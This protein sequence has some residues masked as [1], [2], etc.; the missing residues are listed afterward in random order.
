VLFAHYGARRRGLAGAL[1][2]LIIGVLGVSVLAPVAAHADT[3]SL[4]T[5]TKSVDKAVVLPGQTFT[6][7]ITVDCSPEDCPDARLVDTIPAEFAALTVSPTVNV[8]GGPSTATWGGPDSRTL[9]VNFLKPLTD[10]GVGI[11]SGSGYS[12]QVALSVPANLSPDWAYNGVPV[13]NTAFA[14]SVNAPD[15]SASRDVTVNVPVTVNTTAAAD[16]TPATTR[17]KVGEASSLLLTTGNTS[18]AKATSLTIATPTDPTATTPAT[19]LFEAVNFDAFGAVV[20]PAGADR[21]QVDAYVAGAWVVGT[22]DTAPALPAGVTP[23]SVTGLRVIFTSTSGSELTAG[24]SAGSLAL[25][26]KQR[27]TL[28]TGGASLVTGTTAVA[29]VT[30]TVLVPG[31]AAKSTTANDSYVI[32]SLD[33]KVTGLTVFAPTRIPAGT[34]SVVTVTG[35]NASKGT[36][37]TLTITEPATGLLSDT[38]LVFDGFRDGGSSWPAGATSATITWTVNG[39]AVPA[40]ETFTSGVPSLPVLAGGQ[41]ITGFSIEYSGDIAVNAL[42][43][44]AF[45]V[46]IDGDA[47][48]AASSITLTDG[49]SIGGT[50]DA[51]TA[52]PATP[53]AVLVV[54]APAVALTLDKTVAPSAAVPA[55]GRSTVQLTAATSSDTGYVAPDS[56]TLTDEWGGT[57]SEYWA[58]FDAVAIS[59]TPVSVGSTLVVS[60]RTTGGWVVLDTVDATASAQTYRAALPTPT[61]ITGLKFV[62]S[63]PGGY[64]QGSTVRPTISFQAR[65]QLR[66]ATDPTATFP[67][68]VGYPNAAL[69]EASGSIVVGGATNTVTSTATDSAIGTVKGLD[70]GDGGA[71]FD[72]TW[73]NDPVTHVTDVDS[74]SGQSRVARLAWGTEVRGYDSATVQDP[75]STGTPVAQ[76]VYQAFNLTQIKA[77]TTATDPL[78]AYDMVTAVE[79]FNKNTQQWEPISGSGSACTV[80][81]PCEGGMPVQNLSAAQQESTIGVRVVFAPNDAA[82]TDA[83]APPVGSG[84]ASGPD[85]R[86]LDLVFQVRNT[87]RD[88]TA[89][90]SSPWVTQFR[91]YNNTDNGSVLNTGSLTLDAGGSTTT[92]SDSDQLLILDDLPQVSMTKSAASS[93]LVVPNPND[94]AVGSYP[95]SSFT[96]RATNNSSARA[97]FLRVSDVMPAP[98]ALGSVHN[99]DANGKG[100]AVAPYATAVYDPATNPFE[101]F[102][103]TKV[104]L[105]PTGT[106]ID[107]SKSVVTRWLYNNGSPI[108]T[109]QLSGAT[110]YANN[111]TALNAA[112][113]WTDVIGVSV[114]Y[115]GTDTTGGGTIASGTYVDMRVDVRVRQMLRSQPTT[116]VTAGTVTNTSFTQVWDDVLDGGN[117][118]YDSK[119]ASISL[120]TATLKVSAG[121]TLSAASILESNR[122][123]DITAT[124]TAGHN[125]STASSRQVIIDD[126]GAAFWD[127]FSFRSLGTVT[128]P[129][130]ADLVRVD[131]KL[132]G[133]STWTQ[134][135]A[136]TTAALPAGTT[137]SQ[138]TGIRFVFSKTG[139][140]IFSTAAPAAAW[141]ASAV[142]VV[143]LR[144]T[145]R[146][147]GDPVPFPSSVAAP[148]TATSSN[149]DYPDATATASAS[150]ALDPGTFRVDVEKRPSVSTT[151]AGETVTFSLI[152]TNVGTGYLNNP[153]VVDSLPIDTYLRT[154]GPLLFDPTSELTFSASSGGILPTTGATVAYD[155]STRKIT[156]TWPAGSRLA[157]GEKYTIVVPI[158]VAPGLTSGYGAAT[159]TM[160]VSSDRTLAACTNVSGNGKGSTLG[161]ANTSCTTTNSVSTVSASAISS[162]KGVKGNVDAAGASTSGASNV[163][164]PSTACVA[165]AGGFYR[166][167]CAANTVVGGTDLWKLQFTNGGNIPA[168]TA[169]I[170]DVLPKSGDTYLRTGAARASGYAPVFAGDLQLMT[171]DLSAGTTYTWEVTT[172]ANPCPNFATTDS[173]C[174]TGV[175]WLDGP[176]FPTASYAT[177][178]AIR[179]T[180]DFTAIDA[181]DDTLPPAATLA[182]TYRTV[183]T[184][185]T[186]ADGRAPV[187]VPVVNARAWN[188]FG[189][190]ATFGGGNTARAVEPLKAGVQLATG[191]LQVG[192]A[193]TGDTAAF[194]PTSYQV[195]VSCTVAGAPV[196]IPSSGHLTLASGNAVPYTARIDGIPVGSDCRIVENTTGATSTSYSPAASGGTAAAIAIAEAAASGAAVPAAQQATVTNSYGTTS[197][198]VTKAVSTTTTVGSFGPFSFT[199]A[200]SVNNGTSTLTVPLAG[201]DAAFTLSDGQEKVVT[202]LPVTASC[203]VRESDSDGATSISASVNGGAAAAVVQNQAITVPLGTG[204]QYTAAVTNT[205]A[206]GRLAVTKTIAGD[207]S[208]ADGPFTIDVTCTYDGQTLYDGDFTILGGQ[209]KT[210]TEVFPVGT[211][212][213]IDETD[214]G[215][216]TT[217]TAA[218]SVTIATGTTTAGITNTFTTGTL[219]VV[220]AFTGAGAAAYGAG[221]FEAQVDCTWTKTAGGTALTIPLPNSGRVTLAS[222]N[223]YAASV[224]GLIAGADC[225]VTET[226]TGGATTSMVSAVSPVPAGGTS[227]VTITNDFAVGSLE[228]DKA[229]IGAGASRFGAGPFEVSVACEYPSNGSMVAV[230]LGARAT[231]VLR[232]DADPAKD[233]RATVTGILAGSVCT[234][235]ETDAG[236]AVSS[237][238][239][240][241]DGKATIAASGTAA[242]T[243]TNTFLVGQLEITKT[244]SQALV[245]GD[246]A[247]DYE[248]AVANTGAVDAAGVRVTDSIPATLKVTAITAD[249]ALWTS[250]AVTGKDTDGYGG[251]L[252]CDY[253]PVLVAGD[254]ADPITLGVTVLPEIAQDTIVN[255]AAV[256]STTPVVDGDT[257]DETV[258]VKWLEAVAT[259]TCVQDAPWLDYSVDAHNL[260]VAGRTMT[261]T[262]ADSTGTAIHTD[263]VPITANGPVTG[264]LLWPGAAV[265][266]AGDGI[267]WPG[268]R[269]V[270]AGETPDW[271]NLVLDPAAYGYGLRANATVTISINPQTTLT[272]QYPPATATCGETPDDRDSDIWFTKTAQV[273]AIAAGDT[274]DYRMV[275]GNKGLGAVGSVIL[276]DKVPS[277]LKILAATPQ[278]GAAGGPQWLGCAVS[279]RG[280]DGY[281]GSIRCELDRPLGY[282]QVTPDVLLT[283]KVSDAVA[284]GTI[285]NTAEVTALDAVH[286]AGGSGTLPTLALQDSAM[287]VTPGRLAFTGSSTGIALQVGLLLM[288]LGGLLVFRR[289]RVRHRA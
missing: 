3:G 177:V 194:A 174:S 176:T 28:R 220:K 235:V 107:L 214:A 167:P 284:A 6:Y 249:P 162:F 57:T 80:A 229:R 117:G 145:L 76:T 222:S 9:T 110:L 257:D 37:A 180:F 128:K 251:T 92:A 248:L 277:T 189:V 132:N 281:G 224:V 137:A 164:S 138:V 285:I 129:A 45:A 263:S 184:P 185:S 157:P 259:P 236:L 59:S 63:K 86:T 287:V 15:A 89:T 153:V 233:Y 18:N 130:G 75:V 218:T 155:D 61:A 210:L 253:A 97:W 106:G 100:Y 152:M 109:T 65:A 165:D 77:I 147:S 269:E 182:L 278:A 51:G 123:A 230:D 11:A 134:G 163:T 34:E 183:N 108:A 121:S 35:Q 139:G 255:T 225:S 23:A 288:V 114:L 133:S 270:R 232:A 156:I 240:P 192:K 32:D 190:Y 254:K 170:V 36:L 273:S 169:T 168:Q 209:T 172:N 204:A 173:T 175:T 103:I 166:S 148:V 276:V 84:I 118:Y 19:N 247:F 271:E 275:M 66:G 40:P 205:Y 191:P 149:A 22:A 243:V 228:I 87:L 201:G 112:S 181:V 13:T 29:T 127:A 215:G 245:Q 94:V 239:T 27:A 154:G 70:S 242:V 91:V 67:T 265:N 226:K 217:H 8:T 122:A 4:F 26:L 250:C 31:Q 246:D 115:T 196:T 33:S 5:I 274:F 81:H 39:G 227:T 150:I 252:T 195:T 286:R 93:S 141:S 88:T 146:A 43:K 64:A 258:D 264:S 171:D 289:R 42:A 83:L 111:T 219:R 16:W 20:F 262:W 238:L 267:A 161:D 151:P 2:A 266:S 44:A 211:S 1:A 12:V 68:P 213:A 78:I 136:A 53:S 202:G 197:L 99:S 198:K 131:V 104:V 10:G 73:Q 55:G 212:C 85:A 279:S 62:F 82:R 241:A 256:T 193:I 179:V 199:L 102:L 69:A 125:G 25:S 7:T 60:Y 24:G 30:G 234:V 282:Q 49:P 187:T 120:V 38:R 140:G 207:S 101:K 116:L 41:R 14:S 280:A 72:K 126:S 244:A 74:Q 21:V 206:G 98:T 95:T 105:T 90:P 160:T 272:V 216:A 54:L 260:D 52:T 268:W 186:G 17:F 178:K 158:Q 142:F 46:D 237:A 261:V 56:I 71:L 283:V 47:T 124:V 159:N 119:S 208:Y 223:G 58:A 96:V 188:S 48:G 200:C 231:Q 221:P 50:N 144:D 113:T 203:V 135:V 79:L 143:R